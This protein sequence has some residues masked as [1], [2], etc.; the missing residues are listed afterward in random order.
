MV[1]LNH[2]SKCVRCLPKKTPP[3]II[4]DIEP[5]GYEVV[6]YIWGYLASERRG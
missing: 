2:E 1:N 3:N 4:M 5:G 6:S